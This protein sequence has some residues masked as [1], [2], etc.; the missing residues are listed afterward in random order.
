MKLI[1]LFLGHHW[2]YCICRR[3]SKTR[4]QHHKWDGCKCQV[5]GKT[6]DQDHDWNGCKCRRCF[7][8]RDQHH[9][10]V[11]V[12]THEEYIGSENQ[13][14]VEWGFYENVT[15]YRC[16]RCGHEEKNRSGSTRVQQDGIV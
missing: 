6:R 14:G 10:Y 15:T 7:K 5:C 12:G 8:I 4:D 9:D 13:G 16:S 3:C 11:S 2:D 1:C